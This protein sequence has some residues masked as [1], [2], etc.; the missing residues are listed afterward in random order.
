MGG[1]KK[2]LMGGIKKGL[3]GGDLRNFVLLET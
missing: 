2:G 3:M 1:I